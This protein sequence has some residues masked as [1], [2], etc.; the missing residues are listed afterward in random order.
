MQ[1]MEEMPVA[2]LG[3]E[4]PLEKVMVTHSSIL[5]WRIPWTEEPGESQRTGHDWSNLA[6][7]HKHR[8]P[9]LRGSSW[10]HGLVHMKSLRDRIWNNITEDRVLGGTFLSCRWYRQTEEKFKKEKLSGSLNHCPHFFPVSEYPYVEFIIV[11]NPFHQ[12]KS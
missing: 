10:T 3:G 7:A 4:D 2:F 1:E 11:T 8:D 5:A 12:N 6:Q 9:L